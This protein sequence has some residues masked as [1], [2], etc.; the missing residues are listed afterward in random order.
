[1]YFQHLVYKNHDI[2]QNKYLYKSNK[3]NKTSV[4]KFR[5]KNL[6]GKTSAIGKCIKFY[7]T[8]TKINETSLVCFYLF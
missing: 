3:F 1:M 5:L 8:T 2:F 4:T 7:R 6:V